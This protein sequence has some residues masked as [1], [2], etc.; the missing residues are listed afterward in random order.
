MAWAIV[1]RVFRTKI[2]AG[3]AA[4]AVL[5]SLANHCDEHG[6]EC[7]PGQEVIQA[8]TQ[9][10]LDTIQRQ[11]K[12]LESDDIITRKKR[13]AIRG[14]W[15]SWS[16]QINLEKLVDPAAPCGP[17][18]HAATCGPDVAHQAAPRGFTRP[19]HA[20]SPGRTMRLKP[21][22][23]PVNK[24]S[25]AREPSALDGLGPLG[26]AIRN[27]IG[28]DNF[29]AW[30]GG[31]SIVDATEEAVTLELPTKFKASTIESRYADQVLACL[32]A[33]Q[34][35]IERVRFVARRAA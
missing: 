16:Y 7:Y 14:R 33:Q 9:L 27:R 20:A 23:K 3:S 22:L 34:A 15:A 24:P 11:L 1:D 17:V 26:A 30:F 35:S 32:Q 28:S 19:H 18:D 6:G 12:A 5:L 25:R 31:A 29:S 4:K 8:E 13:P 2:T 10:S 21:I